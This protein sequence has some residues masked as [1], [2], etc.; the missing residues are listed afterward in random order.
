MRKLSSR[1]PVGLIPRHHADRCK[2]ITS[3]WERTMA[4]HTVR[5]MFFVAA[6]VAGLLMTGA[7]TAAAD[8]GDDDFF[9]DDHGRD[10]IFFDD[11]GFDCFGPG[12]FC[13]VF[14][15]HGRHGGGHG[16]H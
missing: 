8:H 5:K 12:P 16:R 4:R 15:D 9:F 7:G 6:T 13:V 3:D 14:D 11:R 2:R 1:V 10:R